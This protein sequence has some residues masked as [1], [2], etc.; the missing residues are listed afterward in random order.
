MNIE[1]PPD[2]ISV[3]NIKTFE[4]RIT[5]NHIFSDN[6]NWGDYMRKH[7]A[8]LRGVEIRE[9][10]KMLH[11]QDPDNGYITFEC[12]QCYETKTIHFNCNSRIC[13]HCGK[14]YT[15]KWA[16]DLAKRLFDVPHRHVVMTMPDVLWHIFKENR[17]LL[18]VLMDS[19]INVIAEALSKKAR[20]P[21]KPAFVVVLHTYGRT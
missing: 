14:K 21:I 6:D 10:Y 3:P 8:E 19:A 20:K 17:N 16:W 5:I 1:T 12:P 9:V 18:K 4:E 2:I 13:T 11:C 7:K 15:D